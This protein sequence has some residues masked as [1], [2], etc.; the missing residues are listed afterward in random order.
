MK[1]KMGTIAEETFLGRLEGLGL[2]TQ[3]LDLALSSPFPQDFGHQAHAPAT[4]A[5]CPQLRQGSAMHM[6]NMWGT[7]VPGRR[8]AERPV[9]RRTPPASDSPLR[10][11]PGPSSGLE[12]PTRRGTASS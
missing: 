6:D 8:C 4:E 3:E 12:P 11:G 9:R 7:T 2:G 1:Y 5:G 10:P